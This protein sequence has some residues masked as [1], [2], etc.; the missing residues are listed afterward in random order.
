M[1]CVVETEVKENSLGIGSV[2][3]TPW[4]AAGPLFVTCRVYCKFVP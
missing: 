4:A 2:T 1:P 3:M